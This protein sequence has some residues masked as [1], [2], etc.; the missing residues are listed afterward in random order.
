MRHTLARSVAA[1]TLTALALAACGGDGDKAA[2]Q[3]PGGGATH[4]EAVKLA[5]QAAGPNPAVRSGVLEARTELTLKGARGFSE[6]FTVSASGPFHFREGSALPD[7]ELE[8][9]VRD[10][11]VTLTSVGGR[12]YVSLGTTGYELPTAVRRRLV[13][14]SSRGANG[15]T[16]TLEQFGIAPARWETEQ[17]IA[18]TERIDGVEVVHIKTSFNAGRMLRDANTLLGLLTSLG[19]TRA[20][21]LPSEISR[22]ARRI[23]VGGVT[24]KV[25][26]SWIGAKDRV[27]RKAHFTLKFTV[28]GAQRASLGGLRGGTVTGDL[29]VTEVGR[30]QKIGKPASLGSYADFQLG[31]D[32]LADAR[33]G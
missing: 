6:P 2:S 24:S 5:N 25:G 28:P 31:L 12:S 8:T 7:Y 22:R 26:A 13:R 4:A 32:A 21:G 14:S 29:H 30:P 23:I 15:L 11:G 10:N 20:T 9:G 33:G 16:R 27:L 3:S 19:V 1:A 17:R 18:G